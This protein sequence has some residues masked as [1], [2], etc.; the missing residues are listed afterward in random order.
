MTASLSKIPAPSVRVYVGGA[1]DPDRGTIVG[2]TLAAAATLPVIEGR[3]VVVGRDS[4]CKLFIPQ[5]TSALSRKAAIVRRTN[6][7]LE[8]WVRSASGGVVYMPGG[9]S[10]PVPASTDEDPAPRPE[11]FDVL[12]GTVVEL[13]IGIGLTAAL[14]FDVPSAAVSPPPTMKG[15]ADAPE[16]T[17][18]GQPAYEFTAADKELLT[19]LS[20]DRVVTPAFGIGVPSTPA[21]AVRML[22]RCATA[23]FNGKG[24]RDTYGQDNLTQTLTALV[25]RVDR[26]EEAA[27]LGYDKRLLSFVSVYKDG[28]HTGTVGVDE[29]LA[30]HPEV[31]AGLDPDLAVRMRAVRDEE[32]E[33]ARAAKIEAG[34]KGAEEAARRRG[35]SDASR[36]SR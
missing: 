31:V 1:Y 18:V 3:E 35:V 27:Q 30:V 12:H 20:P 10:Q 13:V 9:R 22:Q 6:G 19:A 36:S 5:A 25:H 16:S 11:H 7:R 8:M 4:D 26:A 2:G 24:D 28:G 17:V 29:W 34:R 15:D 33:R 21:L 23:Y 32:V 14:V